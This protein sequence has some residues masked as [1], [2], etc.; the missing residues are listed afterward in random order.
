MS[1]LRPAPSAES[2]PSPESAILAESAQSGTRHELEATWR[3]LKGRLDPNVLREEL[4]QC[5]RAGLHQTT[6]EVELELRKTRIALVS[7]LET[8]LNET[9]LLLRSATFGKV[10]TM[11]KEIGTSANAAGRSL[12]ETVRENPVPAAM[13]GLGLLWLALN[14]RSIAAASSRIEPSLRSRGAAAVEG[15]VHLAHEAEVMVVDGVRTAANAAG[16]F[17][18]EAGTSV[19][20]LG[21]SAS[22]EV[23]HLA[24]QAAAE[25]VR[26][27]QGMEHLFVKN[28]LAVGA[29]IF[30]AGAAVGLIL[31]MTLREGRLMG[32]ARNAVVARVEK[33]ASKTL[34]AVET[35]A[36]RAAAAVD[37]LASEAFATDGAM[38]VDNVD[39]T[40]SIT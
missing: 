39:N 21:K 30:A 4:V 23:Q 38:L 2:A 5:V 24:S 27:E 1:E 6:G 19:S 26:V 33:V 18:S 10:E 28:P 29:A 31:P 32:D 7:E 11:F 40:R 3:E 17:A 13:V 34:E 9:K 15:A 37:K 20:G 22:E 12:A 25:G 35:G 8:G 16:K 36:Q 14:A